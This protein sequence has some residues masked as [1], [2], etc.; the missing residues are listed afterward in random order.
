MA[1]SSL[2]CEIGK[3]I[4]SALD[5]LYKNLEMKYYSDVARD[6]IPQKLALQDL[7]KELSQLKD[8]T[9]ESHSEVCPREKLKFKQT[10]LHRIACSEVRHWKKS[11]MRRQFLTAKQ[12]NP[13]VIEFSSRLQEEIF[14]HIVNVMTCK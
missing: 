7:F 6:D 4:S 11:M 3:E 13:W 9:L 14:N 12:S 8:R 2:D 5:T 1:A 10:D